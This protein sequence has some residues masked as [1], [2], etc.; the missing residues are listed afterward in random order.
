MKKDKCE[1]ESECE[2]SKPQKRNHVKTKLVKIALEDLQAV[3]KEARE[4]LIADGY[5]A[6][7]AEARINSVWGKFK[8]REYSFLER[9]DHHRIGYPDQYLAGALVSMAKYHARH[10]SELEYRT[11]CRRDVE[12]ISKLRL[13]FSEDIPIIGFDREADYVLGQID[14]AQQRIRDYLDAYPL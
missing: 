1:C 4:R 11:A 13:R 10:N 6:D 14:E 2:E 8:S 12:E 9:E 7:D 3:A 5:G